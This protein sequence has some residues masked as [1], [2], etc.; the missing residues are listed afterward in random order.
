MTL[1]QLN[2]VL[3]ISEVG[4][5]NKAAELLYV[6]QPSLTSAIKELEKEV[7]IPIFHRSGKG[8]S[9]T[10]DGAEFLLYARQ[11][12]QQYDFL[13]RLCLSLA[14]PPAG[15]VPV[16]YIFSTCGLSLPFF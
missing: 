4:S 14:R 10:N 3:V 2:Y 8:V 11:V 16:N 9:L 13:P 15:R 6:A 12:Y 5:L 7:G 1:Q